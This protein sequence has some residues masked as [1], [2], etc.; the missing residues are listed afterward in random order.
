[1]TKF[2]N[3]WI[4]IGVM[5]LILAVLVGVLELQ[6]GSKEGF[7]V[8]SVGISSAVL[9][10]VVGIAVHEVGHLFV[11]LALGIECRSVLI[12]PLHWIREGSTWRFSM[13]NDAR[14]GG[15]VTFDPYRSEALRKKY[16][17]MY[18][19]GPLASLLYALLVTAAVSR[20]DFPEVR[21]WPAIQGIAMLF[22]WLMVA[23]FVPLK[24]GGFGTDGYW[25]WATVTDNEQ[26]KAMASLGRVIA[27][28]VQLPA[29]GL[30][31][32]VSQVIEHLFEIVLEYPL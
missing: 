22:A 31:C 17:A 18:A 21:I 7:A 5:T 32:Q 8:A 13:T 29:C 25:I 6:I 26:A 23:N 27:D 11:G 24:I 2:V 4:G 12:G 14:I 9:L 19:G 10:F 20:L 30:G 3:T 15:F 28:V 1:M 16:I